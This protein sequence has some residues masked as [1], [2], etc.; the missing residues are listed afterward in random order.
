MKLWDTAPAALV[1]LI[2]CFLIYALSSWEAEYIE[3][4]NEVILHEK[5]VESASWESSELR[6][7][8]ILRKLDEIER[9]LNQCKGVK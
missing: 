5:I 8:E 4:E 1:L 2:I 6:Q 7:I 9:Q 3:M